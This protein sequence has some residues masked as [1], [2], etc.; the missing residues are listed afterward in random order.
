MR[1]F[2]QYGHY[3]RAINTVD[4]MVAELGLRLQKHS[5]KANHVTEYRGWSASGDEYRIEVEIQSVELR[6]EDGEDYY[7]TETV[8]TLDH[9]K[10]SPAQL[11]RGLIAR[12]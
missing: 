9:K 5:D 7:T 1:E 11:S 10:V 4:T 6:D 3:T 12:V 8:V 2:K